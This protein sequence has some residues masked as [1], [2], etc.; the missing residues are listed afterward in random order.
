MQAVFTQARFYDGVGDFLYLFNHCVLKTPNESV[1]EGMGSVLDRHASPA[2]GSLA[3]ELYA[4]EAT[5]HWNG[6][7]THEAESFLTKALNKHFDG[8]E[9]RFW[10]TYG[11]D[12]YYKA[13][14][15]TVLDRKLAE[16]SKFSFMSKP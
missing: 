8:K 12:R 1:V 5:V 14:V 16:K 4:K 9:W 15:S 10:H 7:V 3:A 6:P 13:K 11:R 2:R